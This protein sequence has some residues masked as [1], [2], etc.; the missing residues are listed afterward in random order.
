MK[1]LPISFVLLISLMG[2]THKPYPHNKPKIEKG[3]TLFGPEG[4]TTRFKPVPGDPLYSH[5]HS[6]RS[7]HYPDY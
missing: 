3:I 4:P 5:R 1:L 2:C 6:G 7:K